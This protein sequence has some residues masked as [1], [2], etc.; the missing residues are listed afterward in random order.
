M[1]KR[2]RSTC[3]QCIADVNV[4]LP[5]LVENHSHRPAALHWWEALEDGAAGLSLPVHM[6]LLRLLC[7]R[8]VMGTSVQAPEAAWNIV[9]RLRADP[10]ITCCNAIPLSHE[11]LWRNLI[12]GR[13]PSPNLWTDAWLAALAQ[14][15]GLELVTFDRG[16][17]AFPGLRL[18]LL[19]MP[20]K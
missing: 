14:S 4:L 17:L 16:F 3:L 6:A 12:G 18:R 20:L 11:R 15:L 5:I 19:E 1:Q 10:R 8:R 13:E 7:N 9:Q 2:K